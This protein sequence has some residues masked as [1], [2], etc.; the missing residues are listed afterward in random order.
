VSEVSGLLK[1]RWSKQRRFDACWDLL[2][3]INVESLVSKR[4]ALDDVQA[5]YE[6]LKKGGAL[7]VAFKY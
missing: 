2:R 6:M 3:A 4:V 1:G 5:A 7:A